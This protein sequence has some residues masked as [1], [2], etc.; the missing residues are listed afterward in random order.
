MKK[1]LFRGGV[2]TQSGYGVHGRQIFRFVN[3][4][5]EKYGHQ[6][7][8]QLLPWGDTPWILNSDDENGLIGKI[9]ESTV[10]IDEKK[11]PEKYNVTFQLQ[12]PN[13]WNTDLGN[14]NVGI[15]AGI[16]AT[17]CKKEWIDSCLKMSMVV[18]PSTFSKKTLLDSTPDNLKEMMD[19]KVVVIPE[20]FPDELII[21]DRTKKIQN[22]DSDE[23]SKN[24]VLIIG[25]IT[26]MNAQVD[27][28]NLFYTIRWLCEALKD[29]PD[30][31]IV[32]K[33]NAARNTKIDRSIVLKFIRK[34]LTETRQGKENPK[35]HVIHGDLSREEMSQLYNDDRIKLF[36]SLTRGEGFGLPILE[37]ASQGL[38]IIATN[39]SGHLDFLKD[40]FMPVD[41]KLKN[42]P[43]ALVKGGIFERNSKWAEIDSSSFKKSLMSFINVKQERATQI[44]KAK[45]LKSTIQK[46]HRFNEVEKIYIDKFEKLLK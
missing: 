2:L 12:L 4:M 36:V 44:N 46:S 35:V 20:S 1:V 18:V 28:K 26:G 16:E 7:D 13:E 24:N 17:A 11:L 30:W 45:K 31:G 37:A 40:Q 19:L 43:D 41:Y 15:T 29:K 32:L 39:W 34:L 22:F 25:Q 9:K 6:L 42:V 3:N 14:F 8:T 27:R 33:T 23:F 5:C 38:P 10:D 21:D